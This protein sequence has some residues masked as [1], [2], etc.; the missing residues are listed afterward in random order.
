MNWRLNTWQLLSLA[1]YSCAFPLGI[2]VENGHHIPYAFL[3][4]LINLPF[5]VLLAP[6]L[7]L[8][9]PFHVGQLSG[10]FLAWAI[11][12]VQAYLAFVLFRHRAATAHVSLFHAF[13]SSLGR[14][15]IVALATVLTGGLALAFLLRLPQ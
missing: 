9:E 3:L 1:L 2:Y 14:A 6:L 13:A 4:A 8:M 11:I 10:Q 15:S 5:L 12:F 7:M